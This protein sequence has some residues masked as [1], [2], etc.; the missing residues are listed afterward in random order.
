[1]GMLTGKTGPGVV[2]GIL[3]LALHGAAFAQSSS[4][5]S[6]QA[7]STAP[8]T[9]RT[10]GATESAGRP[11]FLQL[12]YNEDWGFLRDESK[13]S[14]PLDPIKYIPL[15]HEGWYVTVGGELRLYYENFRNETW[16][17][18]PADDNG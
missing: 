5:Q 1:M 7:P 18:E 11:A 14:D 3:G 16:G 6:P 8:L 12:R 17:S 13:R 4:A 15:G 9:D 2:A 10:P